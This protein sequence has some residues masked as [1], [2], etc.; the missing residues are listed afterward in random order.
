MITQPLR[1]SQIW[2]GSR[3]LWIIRDHFKSPYSKMWNHCEV[4]LYCIR[5][6]WCDPRKGPNNEWN[7]PGCWFYEWSDVTF[8]PKSLFWNVYDYHRFETYLI[9]KTWFYKTI[10]TWKNN[11][12]VNCSRHHLLSSSHVLPLFYSKYQIK[13]TSSSVDQFHWLISSMV[14]FYLARLDLL[15]GYPPLCLYP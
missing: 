12:I 3:L 2:Q 4:A 10:R 1:N 6:I 15:P 5:N 9:F 14:I 8:S 11:T 13:H 7:A